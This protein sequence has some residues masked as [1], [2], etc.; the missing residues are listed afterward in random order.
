MQVITK[1]LDIHVKVSN[2]TDQY[3]MYDKIIVKM[4]VNINQ[5]INERNILFFCSSSL[6]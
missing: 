1:F 6:S 2:Y 4:F 5:T 3:T